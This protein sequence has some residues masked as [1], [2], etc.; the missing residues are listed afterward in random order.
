MVTKNIDNLSTLI[1]FMIIRMNIKVQKHYI[2]YLDKQLK[3]E[4]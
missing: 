1:W 3:E 2:R 4:S